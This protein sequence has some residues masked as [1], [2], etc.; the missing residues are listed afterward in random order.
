MHYKHVIS[1]LPSLSIVVSQFS[2]IFVIILPRIPEI[3]S[4]HPV[5]QNDHHEFFSMSIWNFRGY[6]QTRRHNF[7]FATCIVTWDLVRSE[8]PLEEGFINNSPRLRTPAHPAFLWFALPW[9][10]PAYIA[11]IPHP[12][13]PSYRKTF[14]H[15]WVMYVVVRKKGRKLKGVRGEMRLLLRPGRP[16]WCRRLPY[17]DDEKYA[18]ITST[19]E[20]R[21][22]RTIFDSS[23]GTTLVNNSA[24]FFPAWLQPRVPKGSSLTNTI[25]KSSEGGWTTLC[26]IKILSM[27]YILK[28]KI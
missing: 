9:L 22:A 10:L 20:T 17:G 14:R 8:I 19:S 21:Q 25:C 7:V 6:R 26:A 18:S 12:R 15:A 23:S 16:R 2:L 24:P 28:E 27:K 5:W 3:L 11:C 1:S 13:G 4:S